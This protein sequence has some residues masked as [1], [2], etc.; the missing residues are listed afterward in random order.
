MPRR[1]RVRGSKQVFES[2]QV[3][4]PKRYADVVKKSENSAISESVP[5]DEDSST[6]QQKYVSSIT[7]DGK[8]ISYDRWEYRYFPHLLNLYELYNGSRDS[9]S[10]DTDSRVEHYKEMY[11]FFRFLFQVSSGKISS[12][13]E[14]MS[15]VELVIYENY[16]NVIKR[17]N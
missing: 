15:S 7:R 4:K 13:L 5:D 6:E 11:D 10:S 12:Y 8:S 16:R 1:V 2:K 17:N 14:D 9:E 3:P